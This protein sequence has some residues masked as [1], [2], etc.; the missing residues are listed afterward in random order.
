MMGSLRL[1]RAPGPERVPSWKVSLCRTVILGQ[2]KV[3]G[4]NRSPC[5]EEGL[6]LEEAPGQ[7]RG[8]WWV[9]GPQ[10]PAPSL[11]PWTS[12]ASHLPPN[13]TSGKQKQKTGKVQKR[14]L[15]DASY[16]T[17]AGVTDLK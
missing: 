7:G 1:A 3:L 13:Q 16:C 14:R 5:W 8:L 6:V 12:S 15:Q 10:H 17:Q 2:E 11:P 4:Q 9:G